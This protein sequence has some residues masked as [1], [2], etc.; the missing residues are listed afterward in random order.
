[1]LDALLQDESLLEQKRMKAMSKP[2]KVNVG[3]TCPICDSKEPSREHVSRHFSDELLDIVMGFQ[4]PSQCTQCSYKNDKP[5][6]VSI[7]IALVH[8]ILDHFLSDQELVKSKRETHSAKPQKVNIGNQCPVCDAEFTK[9][10]N[11]DHVC[12]HF[13]DEL[14]DLVLSFPDTK[15]CNECSYTSDKLDNLVKHVALGKKNAL[16]NMTTS[17]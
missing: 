6:N 8:S 4:D 14:R 12:W 5:K 11:R 2:K 17:L 7:H 3:S 10:Q 9:G 13:M 15:M 16:K 1:M